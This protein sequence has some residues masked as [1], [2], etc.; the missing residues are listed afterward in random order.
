[1]EINN[2]WVQYI[3]RTAEQILASIRSR[4]PLKCPEITDLTDSNP[5]IKMAGIYAGIAEMLNY[6]IDSN[7]EEVYIQSA[8][9]Y[10]SGIAIAEM[11]GYKVQLARAASTNLKFAINTAVENDIVIPVGSTAVSN[12]IIF[13]TIEQGVIVAG[14]LHTEVKANNMTFSENSINFIGTGETNQEFVIETDEKIVESK[15]IVKVDGIIWEDVRDFSRTDQD[16]Q[17]Y[18]TGV[19]V[20]KK[21]YIKFGDSV[22]GKIVPNGSII[23]VTYNKCD[24]V[25]ANLEANTVFTEDSGNF[26]V[27]NTINASGGSDYESLEELKVNIPNVYRARYRAI[28]LEDFRD[29]INAYTAVAQSAIQY[30]GNLNLTAYIVPKGGGKAPDELLEELSIY[31]QDK[32]PFLATLTFKSAGSL[33]I[34][35]KLSVN[36]TTGYSKPDVVNRVR[37]NI[38]EYFSPE[39][40]KIRPIFYLSDIYEIVETTEGVS[41]SVVKDFIV[42]PYAEVIEGTDELKYEVLVKKVSYTV[43]WKIVAVSDNTFQLFKDDKYLGDFDMDVT[44]DFAEMSI[45]VLNDFYTLGTEWVL[46]TYADLIQTNSISVQE[47]SSLVLNSDN[48]IIE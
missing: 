22:Y 15:L 38:L 25:D 11:L 21:A 42:E 45:K 5:L 33:D 14:E 34:K 20:D 6:Y 39:N 44:H 29:L 7:A 3:D 46:Y 36:V 10:A 4:M 40:Q 8:N 16:S 24:G 31:M 18:T 41:N 35:V 32:L 37:E 2:G 30:T 9:F 19:T 48:L 26:I 1:M 43:K 17:V 13:T 23:Q 12:G 27:T 28:T 47:F